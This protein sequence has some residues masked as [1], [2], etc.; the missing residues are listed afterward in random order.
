MSWSCEVDLLIALGKNF[1]M[2]ILQKLFATIYNMFLGKDCMD[3]LR[4]LI[5]NNG[6]RRFKS[7]FIT[8]KDIDYNATINKF[9]K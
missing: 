5:K 7:F 1:M 6:A 8:Y 9:K 4:D 3:W 2:Q